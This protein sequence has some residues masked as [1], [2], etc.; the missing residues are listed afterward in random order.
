MVGTLESWL[1]AHGFAVAAVEPLVGDL[2][3]RSYFRA[4]LR[5]GGSLLAAYYPTELRAAQRR[6]VAARALLD[7]AGV[8]VPAVLADDPERGFMAVEDLG[9]RTVYDL[10]CAGADVA[11]YV[12]DAAR[13]MTRIARLDPAAVAALGSPP[14]DAALL[15]RELGATFEHL[16][17]GRGFAALGDDGRLFRSA[18]EALC[19]RLGGD[20]AVPCHRDFMVRNLMPVVRG[21]EPAVAVIDFQDLRLGP[22]AY[23]LASLVNDSLFGSAELER[24]MLEATRAPG[25]SVDAYRRAVA[26]RSLKAAGTFA[27]FAAAGNL[28]YRPLIAPTL[29]R[30][31]PHL[32]TLPETREAFARIRGWWRERLGAQAFC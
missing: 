27:R 2:S 3:T 26:Q 28:R 21:G 1:E 10:A 9:S 7:A 12:A 29:A 14:L 25:T 15:R 8:A 17:E 24:S 32:E 23:D 19:E 22:P 30:A 20:A 13:Q 5:G 6:F 4:R 18:L 16:L 31:A 11:P